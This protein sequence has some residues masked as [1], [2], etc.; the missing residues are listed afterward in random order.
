MKILKFVNK[1]T[2]KKNFLSYLI[3]VLIVWGISMWLPL[4]NGDL[5]DSLTTQNSKVHIKKFLL[6]ISLL[7]VLQVILTYLSNILSVK[8]LNKTSFKVNFYVLD[9]VKKLPV[10]FFHDKNSAYLNQRIYVDSSA[11]SEFYIN[12]I[13]DLILNSLSLIISSI[14]LIK[15]NLK[16]SLVLLALT[17]CYF[18]L[19]F[20]FRKKL[21]KLNLNFK[22]SQNIYF[23]ESNSQ[24]ENIKFIK[25]N[26]LFQI[27]NHNLKQKFNIVYN[28]LCKLTTA[29]SLFNCGGMLFTVLANI[30]ILILGVQQILN[31]Y[32]TIGKF[33]VISTYFNTIISGVEYWLSFLEKYQKT[34]VSYNRIEE[35]LNLSKE[36]NGENII[37]SIDT[38]TVNN[39]S[40]KYVNKNT[41]LSNINYEFRK[42]FI[43]KIEGKNGIGKSSLINIITGLYNGEYEGDILYNGINILDLDMYE[44]RKNLIGL[45]D[46]E[47]ILLKESIINN[48]TYNLKKYDVKKLESL[49]K[50]LKLEKFISKLENGLFTTIAENSSNIS[51]GEKQKI[52]IIRTILKNP[53]LIILDEANSA[54]DIES[55]SILKSILEYEKSNKIIILIS[56][57]NLLDEIVDFEVTLSHSNSLNTII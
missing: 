43:Y 54:L 9:Y 47:P 30:V 44:I 46:Q 53:D 48:M 3:I 21:Y 33:T 2:N 12:D 8:L 57:S 24:I 25:I 26:S 17:P 37:K 16:I 39:L 49:I 27:M 38:I 28:D 23:G 6:I 34:L 20:S 19:Y 10:F 52:S 40:F 13:K 1:Y 45:V 51:G 5:I 50:K 55:I 15:I 4:I 42:G 7:S 32:L 18:I 56:H 35:L 29:N 11:T 41:I 31:G 36:S 22:E 14:I